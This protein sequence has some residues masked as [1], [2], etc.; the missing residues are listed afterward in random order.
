[1]IPEWFEVVSLALISWILLADLLIT[2]RR[3]HVPT[4]RESAR[5]VGAYVGLALVFALVLLIV[6]GPI[7]R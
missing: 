3:P 1:M 5:W 4:V 2:G 6:G 7:R